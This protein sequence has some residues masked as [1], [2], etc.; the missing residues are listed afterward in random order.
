M[1][2]SRP[3]GSGVRLP[4][5]TELELAA[6]QRELASASSAASLSTAPRPGESLVQRLERL[7]EAP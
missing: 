2:A 7:T 6:A 4:D 1:V 3:E 5:G